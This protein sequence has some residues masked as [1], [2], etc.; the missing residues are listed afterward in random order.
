[1]PKAGSKQSLDAE[2][3]NYGPYIPCSVATE[4]MHLPTICEQLDFAFMLA[5]TAQNG[6]P[7]A[8]LLEERDLTPQPSVPLSKC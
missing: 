2:T 4:V 6:S 8:Q 3:H 7:A 5:R 1:M